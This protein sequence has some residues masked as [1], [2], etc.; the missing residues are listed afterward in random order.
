MSGGGTGAWWWWKNRG[1]RRFATGFMPSYSVWPVVGWPGGWWRSGRAAPAVALGGTILPN[2]GNPDVA[3]MQAHIHFKWPGWSCSLG[4]A[5]STASKFIFLWFKLS[6]ICKIQIQ[7]FEGYKI[8]QT[9]H[10]GSYKYSEQIPFW[11]KIQFPNRI[12]IKILGNKLTL[13]LGWIYWALKPL[14][15][16]LVNSPNFYPDFIFR[17]INLVCHVCMPKCGVSKYHSKVLV[18]IKHRHWIWISNLTKLVF[19]QCTVYKWW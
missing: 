13:N 5:Q 8:H 12:L 17:N 6:Q 15:K 19:L 14:E 9:L 7:T 3:A 18:W 10:E 1:E 4:L 16:D 2:R 11:K